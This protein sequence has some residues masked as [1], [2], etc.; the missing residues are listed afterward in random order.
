MAWLGIERDS[1][2]Q[3]L[4]TQQQKSK[5]GIDSQPLL[6]MMS[7][8]LL[9]GPVRKKRVRWSKSLHHILY[10]N[11]I[12]QAEGSGVMNGPTHPWPEQCFFVSTTE[13][14]AE[15]SRIPT[16][17]PLLPPLF[18]PL[19]SLSCW[20]SLILLFFL[21]HLFL[22]FCGVYSI[23]YRHVSGWSLLV[24]QTVAYLIV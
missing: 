1:Y 13:W 19:S 11:L 17:H 14:Q 12:L 4:G 22:V 6:V 21:L 16:S 8:L 10:L 18:L 5:D 3:S 15:I 2:L 7:L 23:L 20:H 24:K 9:L